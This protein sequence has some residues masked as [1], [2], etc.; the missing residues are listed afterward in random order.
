LAAEAGLID[1]E[2]PNEA[3]MSAENDLFH[4]EKNGHAE[5]FVMGIETRG[6][7]GDDTGGTSG[8]S[9]GGDQ[10]GSEGISGN[11]SE[12]PDNSDNLDAGEENGTGGGNAGNPG[13]DPPPPGGYGGFPDSEYLGQQNEEEEEEEEEVG[14][15]EAHTDDVT[16]N[17][18]ENLLDIPLPFPQ[19]SLNSDVSLPQNPADGQAVGDLENQVTVAQSAGGQSDFNQSVPVLGSYGDLNPSAAIDDPPTVAEE[20]APQETESDMDENVCSNNPEN[21]GGDVGGKDGMESE[22]GLDIP[23]LQSLHEGNDI[24]SNTRDEGNVDNKDNGNQVQTGQQLATG[25]GT[26]EEALQANTSQ[27]QG[28]TADAS[29]AQESQA[30]T[31]RAKQSSENTKRNEQPLLTVSQTGDAAQVKTEQL[32]DMD[33]DSDALA[34]LASAALGCDQASTNGVKADLQVGTYLC[35]CKTAFF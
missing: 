3:S 18:P 14:Q 8:N 28:E 19:T 10:G 22:G 30:T 16:Q 35:E 5:E 17:M 6:N 1:P 34:T 4:V 11:P 20:D 33:A 32:D 2:S 13:G 21:R 24:N 15:M 29:N 27:S 25:N 23:S 12:N 9:G 31:E 7:P 26:L